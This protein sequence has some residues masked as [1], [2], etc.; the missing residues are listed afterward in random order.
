MK[1]IR[2]G[3]YRFPPQCRHAGSR[4]AAI[5]TSTA[6]TGHY[7]LPS[8]NWIQPIQWFDELPNGG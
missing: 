8:G 6:F 2:Y 4:L 5:V 3:R 7:L 1:K